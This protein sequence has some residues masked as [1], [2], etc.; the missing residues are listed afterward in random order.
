MKTQQELQLEDKMLNDKSICG[1]RGI[2]SISKSP[3][4]VTTLIQHCCTYP[5][6]DVNNSKKIS[7]DYGL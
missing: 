4:I 6:H 3:S 2:N 7:D 5:F 1:Y